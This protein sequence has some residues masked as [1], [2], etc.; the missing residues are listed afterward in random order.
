MTRIAMLFTE[1][2]EDSE[3]ARPLAAFR[4][5]GCRVT[6]IAPEAGRSYEGKQGDVTLESEM[7]VAEADPSKFDALFLPGGHSPEKLRLVP[8]AV[9]FVRHF[10]DQRKPVAAICHGP[11]ML[12]SAGAVK[13]RTMTCY[14]SIAI[15]LQNAGA[16]YVDQ[17][18]AQDDNY[19]TSRKPDDLDAFNEAALKL[20]SRAEASSRR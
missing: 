1:E 2:F 7:A 3:A 20:F 9:D 12:I 16:N 8:G 5:A 13:G 4:D 11:Q 17:A 10:T 14:D 18:V 19:V 6:L 15:D